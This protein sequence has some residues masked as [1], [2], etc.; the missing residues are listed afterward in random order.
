MKHTKIKVALREAVQQIA[1]TENNSEQQDQ[2]DQQN[3]TNQNQ[4]RL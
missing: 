4:S 2:Q 3:E 1:L